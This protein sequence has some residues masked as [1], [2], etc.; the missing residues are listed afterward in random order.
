MKESSFLSILRHL[1]F[2]SV[3][4]DYNSDFTGIFQNWTIKCS[5]ILDI[6]WRV[7]FFKYMK[8]KWGVTALVLVQSWYNGMEKV[9]IHF[10]MHVSNVLSAR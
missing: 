9:N 7:I 6:P 1:V 8:Q 2:A 10:K 4:A 5:S 3:K